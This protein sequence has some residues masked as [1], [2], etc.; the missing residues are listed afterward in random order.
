MV[1]ER[2][3]VPERAMTIARLDPRTGDRSHGA[4]PYSRFTVL[5]TADALPGASLDP[6]LTDLGPGGEA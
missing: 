3:M 6:G 2:A 5:Q 4:P 1:S